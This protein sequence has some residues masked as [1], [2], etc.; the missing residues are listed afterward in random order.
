MLYGIA[1]SLGSGIGAR[2]LAVVNT[3]GGAKVIPCP[4]RFY[5]CRAN[6]VKKRQSMPDSVQGLSYLSDKNL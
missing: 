5:R 2:N 3:E 1:F 6:L 4:V